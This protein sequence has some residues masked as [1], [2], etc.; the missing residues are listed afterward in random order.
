M[1]DIAAIFRL[2]IS[3]VPSPLLHLSDRSMKNGLPIGNFGMTM[4][5]GECLNEL[6][7]PDQL[8]EMSTA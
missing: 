2:V 6:S 7:G 3:G 5:N 1:N 4:Q 8:E